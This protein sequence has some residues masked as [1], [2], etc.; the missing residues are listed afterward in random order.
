MQD[1]SN[2][3]QAH[4]LAIEDDALLLRAS[5]D[6][7]DYAGYQ[8]TTI[9]YTGPRALDLDALQAAGAPPDVIV[10]DYSLARD[11]KRHRHYPVDPGFV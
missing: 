5:N 7:L 4:V 8:L 6:Y 10:C 11:P 2:F 9:H 3:S 1:N